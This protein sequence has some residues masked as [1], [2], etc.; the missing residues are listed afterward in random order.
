MKLPPL[1]SQ[2]IPSH[3]PAACEEATIHVEKICQDKLRIAKT[4]SNTKKIWYKIIG[5]LSISSAND[6]VVTP[7]T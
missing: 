5:F 1:K 4:V 7:F 2:V 3:S 6:I